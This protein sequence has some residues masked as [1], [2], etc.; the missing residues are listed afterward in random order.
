MFTDDL[1][2]HKG[3]KGNG[4]GKKGHINWKESIGYKVKFNYEGIEG[5]VEIVGYEVKKSRVII[6][7]LNNELFNIKTG[8]FV[9]CCL[10][11]I[12]GKITNEFKVKIGD[13]FKDSKRDLT[14][15][16]MKYTT[17]TDKHG[18]KTNLKYY[19]YKCNNCG[20]LDDRSWMTENNLIKRKIGCSCCAGYTTVEGINSIVDTDKWMIPYFQGGYDEAK[21]YV[22]GSTKKIRP[23]C[24]D[25]GRIKDKEMLICTIHKYHSI[26]C[27][28]GSGMKY[29]EKLMFSILEQLGIDFETQKLSDMFH[30]D[31]IKR[32]KYD[33]YI[34]SLNCII[35]THGGQHY[36]KNGFVFLNGKTL[37]DEIEN[38]RIKKKLAL[39][40]GVIEE[41][42][43]VINC[44]YSDLEYIKDKVIHS[45]LNNLF[46]L[47][48]VNWLQAEEFAVSNLVKI[49]CDYKKDNIKLSCNDIGKL[50]NL[51]SH[52][53][54]RYLKKGTI[55]GWCYYNAK[56]EMKKS[57]F[58]NGGYNAKVVECFKEGISLGV[59]KSCAE[60]ER[61]SEKLFGVKLNNSDISGVCL[62]KCKQSK[63]YTFKYV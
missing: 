51:S 22:N 33:F 38:D 20:W 7:Y 59:F 44:K 55:L 23:I 13:N 4:H 46:D 8:H 6:K 39:D 56:E 54:R 34:S 3:G 32:K 19:Q 53:I 36:F 26:A 58:I 17:L 47:S 43:I 45:E 11:K 31:N 1:P 21:Q 5:A 18:W 16:D 28:C 14:I 40:N 41:N 30:D 60:L 63:G 62:G 48:K 25:C 27:S 50:M 49:A 2:R 61:Q 9:N 15:I 29:N 52:T 37:E 24:P 12:V 35:E 10:G 42:Y 57:G